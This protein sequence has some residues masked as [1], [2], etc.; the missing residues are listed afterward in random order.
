MSKV[1]LTPEGIKDLETN[2]YALTDAALLAQAQ[3]VYLDFIGW[4][5]SNIELDIDQLKWLSDINDSDPVFI[6]YVSSKTSIAMRNRLPLNLELPPVV[7]AGSFAAKKQGKW[8]ME[9]DA[10]TPVKW[11]GAGRII[12]SG[13]I[14]VELGYNT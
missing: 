4:I 12:A 7:P 10:I 5:D 8:I 14:T 13:Q 2:L 1:P 3:D 6:S 9:K 11:D